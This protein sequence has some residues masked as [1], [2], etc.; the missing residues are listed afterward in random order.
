MPL[1]PPSFNEDAWLGFIDWFANIDLDWQ[2][3]AIQSSELHLDRLDWR[4]GPSS[5]TKSLKTSSL[6]TPSSNEDVRVGSIDCFVHIDLHRRLYTISLSLLCPEGIGYIWYI[7]YIG[8]WRGLRLGR[9]WDTS[10]HLSGGKFRRPFRQFLCRS[11]VLC[12]SFLLCRS[13][14]RTQR[15]G[16]EWDTFW[17]LSGG[18]FCR[19]FRQFLCQSRLLCWSRSRTSFAWTRTTPLPVLIDIKTCLAMFLISTRNTLTDWWAF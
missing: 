18:K 12:W 2:L 3:C 15:L 17:Y 8:R 11:R 13:H 19:S 7:G 4:I 14:S 6:L 16:R 1:T 10:W 9:L 5:S